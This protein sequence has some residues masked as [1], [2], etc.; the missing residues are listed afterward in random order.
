[1]SDRTGIEWS[2]A[3]WNPTTGCSK[4]S[5]GCDGCYAI[6]DGARLQHLAAYAN[7][8][9]NGDWTGRVNLVTERLDQPLRWKRPRL[10]FVDSM[11][12][13]FHPEVPD[14]YIAAVWA[15]MAAAGQHTFQVLT[16]RPRRAAQM[17][18][19]L[20]ESGRRTARAMLDVPDLV[21]L[22]LANVWLGTSI[23]S[24]R[25]AWRADHIR[26]APAEV[27]FL[28]LEPLIGPLPSLE[29]TGIDWVIVGGESGPRARPMEL[30]WARE[31]VARCQAEGVPVFVKQLGSLPGRVS[32]GDAKR[33]KIENFPA[34]LRVREMPKEV[35]G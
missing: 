12:D 13:L 19:W 14:S 32:G 10:V 16:K 23:E 2:E 30:S 6:R 22:P 17:G 11:S 33:S 15:V 4:V 24:D 35:A 18:T 28:S 7:T 9:A 25:Y 20:G 21:S 29:L 26:A 34:D 27:R 8:I 5:P 31:I 3:T 1:M